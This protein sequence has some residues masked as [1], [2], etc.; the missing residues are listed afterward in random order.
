M[1][2]THQM[3]SGEDKARKV[4]LRLDERKIARAIKI[5]NKKLA[6]ELVL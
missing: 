1:E 6:R 5:K 4:K 2:G 3:S